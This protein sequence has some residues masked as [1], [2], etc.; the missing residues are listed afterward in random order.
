MSARACGQAVEQQTR[1]EV[2]YRSTLR[3][4][5]Y[6]RGLHS[7]FK[8]LV[9]LSDTGAALESRPPPSVAAA[10]A[11][12]RELSEV[13]WSVYGCEDGRHRLNEEK[14]EREPVLAASVGPAVYRP[15]LCRVQVVVSTCQDFASRFTS[16]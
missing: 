4:F 15:C 13:W 12:F 11:D 7:T 14:E 8:D 5:A 9:W 16:R 6:A 10:S 3:Y 1:Q 2:P